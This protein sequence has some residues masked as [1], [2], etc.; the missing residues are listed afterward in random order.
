VLSVS[1]SSSTVEIGIKV[2]VMVML[3]SKSVPGTYWQPGMKI[4]PE[5]LLVHGPLGLQ[6]PSRGTLA[7]WKQR[8]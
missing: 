6:D 2:K 5:N 4:I 8:S 1:V 7:A 3:V